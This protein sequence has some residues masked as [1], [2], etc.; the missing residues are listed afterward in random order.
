MAWIGGP[1][2][3]APCHDQRLRRPLPEPQR[4]GAVPPMKLSEA[5]IAAIARQVEAL[6]TERRRDREGVDGARDRPLSYAAL[7]AQ[8]RQRAVGR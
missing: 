6:P 1:P 2:M 5:D 3:I 7:F 4:A 8:L